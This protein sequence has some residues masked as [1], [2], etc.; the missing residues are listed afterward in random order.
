MHVLLGDLQ[1]RGHCRRQVRGFGVSGWPADYLLAHGIRHRVDEQVWEIFDV[2][3]GPH[4]LM[5]C[6][7]LR[8]E[9]GL[10]D[11]RKRGDLA[12]LGQLHVLQALR[13]FG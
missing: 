13:V 12:E 2:V 5:P 7:L 8:R 3:L 1:Q 6:D 11:S 10:F 4:H 9:N